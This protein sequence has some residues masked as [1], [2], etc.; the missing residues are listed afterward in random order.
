MKSTQQ[1]P[2]PAKSTL[3]R[4]GQESSESCARSQGCALRV[5]L[6]EAVGGRELCAWQPARGVVWVQTRNARHARRLSQR[7][8]GRL[9]ARGVA[10]GYLRTFEFRRS[11]GWAVKLM[12]RYLASEKATNGASGRTICPTRS[13]VAEL[14]MGQRA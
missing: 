13:R 10:G 11:M 5:W 4:K 1:I 8:D 12:K 14:T 6:N 2:R 9:V 3:R 7:S